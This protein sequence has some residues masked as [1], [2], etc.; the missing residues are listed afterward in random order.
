MSS[1]E[2]T[3]SSDINLGVKHNITDVS[4]PD[5]VEADAWTKVEA[6]ASLKATRTKRSAAKKV[7][8]A[9][10]ESML[11]S[12][13][14]PALPIFVLSPSLTKAIDAKAKMSRTPPVRSRLSHP[15]PTTVPSS[16][17]QW[18]KSA[19]KAAKPTS[20]IAMKL[21]RV[22]RKVNAMAANLKQLTKLLLA[23][24]PISKIA[25]FLQAMD[26]E[27]S[28]ER[29]G[30][31]ARRISD[32]TQSDESDA[33]ATTDGTSATTAKVPVVAAKV[34]DGAPKVP[35]DDAPKVPDG[36]PKVP[37]DVVTAD[38]TL[39]LNDGTSDDD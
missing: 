34:P 6:R 12:P 11:P 21:L 2:G 37:D 7:N 18:T 14:T 3:H 1:D 20:A 29:D 38:S 17:F 5:V 31:T 8:A 25:N 27:S 36:A 32:C 30:P 28:S 24:A 19:H 33:P 13:A 39:D 10:A 23:M 15:P 26:S 35:D 22:D 16:N 4:D 9:R